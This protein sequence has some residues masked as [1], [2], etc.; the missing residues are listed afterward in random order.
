MTIHSGRLRSSGVARRGTKRIDHLEPLELLLL[1]VL[2]RLGRD[3]GT[4]PLGQAVKPAVVPVLLG[5][6]L[7]GVVELLQERAHGLGSDLGLELIVALLA[8]LHTEVVVLVFVKQVEVLDILRTR[9]RDHVVRII[10]DL[11]QL[12][13]RHAHEIAQL[14][15]ERLEEPDVADGHGELDVPHALAPDLGKGDLDPAA[16]TDVPA[17]A[18]ALELAAVALPVLHRPEDALA[19]EAI[20]LGL[21]RTVVDGL[22]LHDLAIRPLAD[23]FRRGNADLDEVEIRCLGGLAIAWKVDHVSRSS[24]G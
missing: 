20:L 18:N 22:G 17:V 4:E 5:D 9:V 16:V 8:R 1:P 23:L 10:D 24:R 3:L 13:E 14:R 2:R 12:P 11:F 6:G 19:E 21:E 7:V 15:R